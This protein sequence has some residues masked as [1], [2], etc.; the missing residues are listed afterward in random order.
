MTIS[1]IKKVPDI[2]VVRIPSFIAVTSRPMDFEQLLTSF[3][4]WQEAN[5]HLF[6]PVIFDGPDFLWTKDGKAEW[7]WAIHDDMVEVDVSPYKIVN[8]KG[9]LYAVAV[10]IDEDAESNDLVMQKLK[11]WV[12]NTN[13]V[14]DEERNWMGHMIY[15]DEEIRNGLG[16]NQMNIYMPIKLKK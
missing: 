13:F 5:N 7:I 1:T 4:E 14:I 10:S 16:Y 3:M 12:K 15:A 8:F 9:G 2:M 11:K 6:K